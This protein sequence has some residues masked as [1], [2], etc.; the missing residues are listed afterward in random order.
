MTKQQQDEHVVFTTDAPKEMLESFK[1]AKA[2]HGYLKV[3]SRV[4]SPHDRVVTK[5]YADAIM[6]Y[7]IAKFQYHAL[8]EP[9]ADKIKYSH[10]IEIKGDK[11]KFS[12]VGDKRPGILEIMTL[13]NFK[14]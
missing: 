1:E 6:N 9:Y 10:N 7:Q 4:L 5:N 13:N 2:L 3:M 14:T 12:R 11:I 8:K